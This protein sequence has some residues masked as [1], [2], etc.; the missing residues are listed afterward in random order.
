MVSKPWLEKSPASHKTH[1]KE[2]GATWLRGRLATVLD[3]WGF[4][5]VIYLFIFVAVC[6]LSLVAMSKGYSWFWYAG[7]SLR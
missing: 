7:F 1:T 3:I 2:G 6:R 5:K 4:F